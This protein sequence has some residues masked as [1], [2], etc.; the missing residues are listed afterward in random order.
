[1]PAVP[2]V[3]DRA[4]TRFLADLG[5]LE[6]IEAVHARPHFPPHAH[7][8][9]ALGVVDWGVNRFRYRGAWHAAP[10]GALCTVTPDEVHTVEAAGGTGFA[11]RCLYPPAALLAEIAGALRGRPDRRTP[12]LPPVIEDP[13]AARLALRLLAGIDGGAAPLEVE[14]RL[15]AL[16]AHVLAHH[17]LPRVDPAPPARPGLW[18]ERAR[19]VLAS[20]LAEN[21]T[22]G[23]VA[24]EAG[25]GRF[26]LLRAF[27]RAYGLTPHAWV[28]QERVRRAQALLRAG[29]A[30][31]EVAA[32]LGFTDQSHLTRHFKRLVG[33]TP[34]C[35]RGS[36]RA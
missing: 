4:R 19:E 5:G 27:A 18:L 17:G 3:R 33:V 31:A 24:A 23:E 21:V 9:Y 12:F 28:I 11:Y 35:Y 30:P 7:A 26:A 6:L 8:T 16:V 20:R 15:G 22:L 1:M 10:A 32:D 14:A 25:V 29:R 36:P 2:T 34:G 13:A